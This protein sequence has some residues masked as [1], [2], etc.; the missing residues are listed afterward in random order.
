MS[1][2]TPGPWDVKD[3]PHWGK[4]VRRAI[5]GATQAPPI[6]QICGDPRSAAE[7]DANARL[8]AAAPDLLAALEMVAERFPGGTELDPH[9][10]HLQAVARRAIALAAT[11]EPNDG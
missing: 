11:K 3:M 9:A 4:G 1:K 10:K 7:N 6:A 5:H 2:H 8:I